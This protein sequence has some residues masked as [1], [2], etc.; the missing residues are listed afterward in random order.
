VAFSSA[1]NQ[2]PSVASAR[3]VF[4]ETQVG[5]RGTDTAITATNHDSK[6]H[7]GR[8]VLYCCT[9]WRHQMHQQGVLCKE[10]SYAQCLHGC[11][12]AADTRGSHVIVSSMNTG[13]AAIRQARRHRA[14]Q[15]AVDRELSRRRQAPGRHGTPGQPVCERGGSGSSLWRLSAI[16]SRRRSSLTQTP[17]H[18]YNSESQIPP[19]L[20]GISVP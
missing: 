8:Q 14:G 10:T 15:P 7:I 18:Q 20:L 9:V 12:C 16:N 6:L 13:H 5:I 17:L 11:T 2:L 4:S 1:R 3:R 19:R